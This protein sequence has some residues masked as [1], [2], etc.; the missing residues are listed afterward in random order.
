MFNVSIQ[1]ISSAATVIVGTA[2]LALSTVAIA[3]PARADTPID[4]QKVVSVSI[5]DALDFPAGN[6]SRK[7]VVTV[8]VTVAADGTLTDASVAKSSGVKAFDLEAVRAAKRVRFPA[9]GKTQTVAL[10]LGFG[11]TATALDAAQGKQIV[12]ARINDRRRL[13][14]TETKVQPVG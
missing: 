12:D 2:F 13:L 14:A 5:N 10:V 8:A 4:F 6:A 1:S 3:T 11:Q 7:G 9:T